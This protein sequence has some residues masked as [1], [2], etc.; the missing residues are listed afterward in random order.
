MFSSVLPSL[1]MFSRAYLPASFARL[2]ST[3]ASPLARL[4]KA[5]GYPIGKCKKA[6][7]L[8][9]GD[10]EKS[11]QWLHAEARKGGWSR[12][13]NLR[14]HP[15]TQGLVGICTQNN[16]AAMV[17]VN[18][19]SDFVARNSDF[20]T[21]FGKVLVA[22][23]NHALSQPF[24]QDFTKMHLNSEQLNSLKF[25]N[26]SLAELVAMACGKFGENTIL[27]RATCIRT[28]GDIILSSYVHPS[29]TLPDLPGAEMGKYG[30]L[31]AYQQK[32][33][34]SQPVDQQI[35]LNLCSKVCQHV[36]GMNPSS[37]GE[38]T[39]ENLNTLRKKKQDRDVAESDE[40]TSQSVQEKVSAVDDDD[41]H[42]SDEEDNESHLDPARKNLEVNESRLL[43]QAF[44]FDPSK[45]IG[46]ALA[47]LSLE[48]IDFERFECGEM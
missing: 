13:V 4:R 1:R 6:L 11:E 22:C 26:L 48:V 3:Q 23:V 14:S 37:L 20:Q 25:E 46:E 17:E 45:V 32:I 2:A 42:T 16:S 36:V 7:E 21:F 27:K 8:N 12:M 5:T 30:A 28:K 29:K 33:G 31:V 18:C 47:P 9:S 10:I 43:H 34:A 19:E 24:N 35:L 40:E 41:S 38:F 44:L 15:A 39:G